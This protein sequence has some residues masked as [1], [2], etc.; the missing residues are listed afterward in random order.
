[1]GPAPF[2]PALGTCPIGSPLGLGVPDHSQV[3]GLPK[4][5]SLSLGSPPRKPGASFRSSRVSHGV[6][7]ECQLSLSDPVLGGRWGRLAT[8]LGPWGVNPAHGH[9]EGAPAQLCLPPAGPC[10]RSRAWVARPGSPLIVGVTW[11]PSHGISEHRRWSDSLH[12][13]QGLAKD[14]REQ[15]HCECAVGVTPC[16]LFLRKHEE[17]RTQSSKVPGELHANSAKCHKFSSDCT[18]LVNKG[19]QSPHL[20]LLGLTSPRQ[21]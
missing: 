5:A 7:K 11:C 13:P 1:M 12:S 10:P 14:P 8:G 6:G 2:P 15:G 4:F 9:L 3:Q 17:S 21:M 18:G 19:T 16:R 20:A